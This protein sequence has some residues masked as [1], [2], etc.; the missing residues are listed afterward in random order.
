MRWSLCLPN[1]NI[2]FLSLVSPFLYPYPSFFLIA[3]LAVFFTTV[4]HFFLAAVYL[5]KIPCILVCP[6]PGL[7]H[8]QL[9]PGWVLWFRGSP[10]ACGSEQDPS[11][12]LRLFTSVPQFPH[13]WVSDCLFVCFIACTSWE[14]PEANKKLRISLRM[15]AGVANVYVVV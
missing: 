10:T 7:V 12:F 5:C 3:F 1:D 14:L 8:L 15:K 9:F 6:T 2:C 11:R 4:N 13:Q